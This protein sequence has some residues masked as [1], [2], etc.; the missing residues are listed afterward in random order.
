MRD[1]RWA[2]RVALVIFPLLVLLGGARSAPA[3]AASCTPRPAVGVT[4]TPTGPQH[5]DLAV[6]L[7]AGTSAGVPN[8]QLD[9]VRFNA[10]GYGWIEA[11]S[12]TGERG[13]FDVALPAGTEQFSFVL[14]ADS[15]GTPPT[16]HLVVQDA[17]G[18]WPTFVGGYSPPPPPPLPAYCTPR[19]RVELATVPQGLDTLLATLRVNGDGN[20]LHAVEVG[21]VTN[22]DLDVAGQTDVTGNAAITLPAGTQ[23]LSFTIHHGDGAYNVGLT[24]VDGCGRWP[25]FVSAGAGSFSPPPPPPYDP[26]PPPHDPPPPPPHDDPPAPAATPE[27][28]S[29]LLFVVG[30]AGLAGAAYRQRR[31]RARR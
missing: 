13:S 21:P 9:A 6:T 28:D 23:Q 7:T 20:T 2:T 24:A 16:A 17:C 31:S 5:A 8:N 10:I 30:A 26:P 3:L 14:H 29:L 19:P 11:G 12:Q 15:P 18:A 22:A 4:V 25:T 27:L 1:Y